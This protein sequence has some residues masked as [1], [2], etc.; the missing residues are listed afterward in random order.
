MTTFRALRLHAPTVDGNAPAARLETLSD[1]DLSAGD[2][3]LALAYSSIN[4][5]DALVLAGR[6]GIVR[7]YPRIGGIDLVGTVCHS[8]DPRWREGDA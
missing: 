5:K 1:S 8:A 4:Y 3:T 7:D 2:V 6:N